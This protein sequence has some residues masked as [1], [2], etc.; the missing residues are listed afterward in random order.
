MI[1]R[2]HNPEAAIQALRAMPGP[3]LLIAGGYDKNSTYDAWAEEFAGKV[4]YL[5]LIGKN[6]R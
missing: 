1:L 5:V 2:E 6:Q 4:K 3:V